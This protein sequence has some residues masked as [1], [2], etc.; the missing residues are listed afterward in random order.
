MRLR[1]KKQI[2]QNDS[3]NYFE[4]DTVFNAASRVHINII[5]GVEHIAI[6]KVDLRQPVSCRIC[7]TESSNA[8]MAGAAQAG[9]SFYFRIVLNMYDYG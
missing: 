2:E 8:Q 1:N 9:D 3:F 4:R 5:A 7:R 6:A